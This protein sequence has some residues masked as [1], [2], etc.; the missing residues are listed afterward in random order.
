MTATAAATL[1]ALALL[2]S[3]LTSAR[4]AGIFTLAGAADRFS[5]CPGFDASG[6]PFR[7]GVPAT[8]ITH[9]CAGP[10]LVSLPS[11]DP[12][13][14]ARGKL[15]RLDGRGIIHHL[16]GGPTTGDL[17]DGGP[18]TAAGLQLYSD[19]GLAVDATGGVLV[20]DSSNGDRVRRIAPDG[21]IAT[22]AG[23]SPSSFGLDTEVPDGA[24]AV[25][26]PLP[27]GPLAAVSGGGFA[28]VTRDR[29]RI[30]AVRPD[31]TV[32]TLAGGLGQPP[33]PDFITALAAMPG[34]KL[35]FAADG[36]V[37]SLE[38]GGVARVLPGLPPGVH[39]LAAA[40]GGSLLAAT[41][42]Q[43]WLVEASG[44]ARLVAGRS[45]GRALDLVGRGDGRS[46][47]R[48]KIS[49][50]PGN[51]LT[52][53]TDGSFAILDQ[54]EGERA[55]RVRI[56]T[57][58]PSARLAAEILPGTLASRG[59]VKLSYVVT[60][61]ADVQV[62]IRHEGREIRRAR[63]TAVPGTNVL[64]LRRRLPDGQNVITLTATAGSGVATDRMAMLPNGFL[65]RRAAIAVI[66]AG[67]DSSTEP[68]G[69]PVGNAARAP[70]AADTYEIVH[71]VGCRRF[72]R[73]RVDC[74][75][76]ATDT[77]SGPSTWTGFTV[78]LGH[79][80]RIYVRTYSNAGKSD[81]HPRFHRH[82]RWRRR[83]LATAPILIL[84]GRSSR[85]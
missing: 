58:I 54:P 7:P 69:T 34:G 31:G 85:R 73:A 70:R 68:Y 75:R 10:G 12:V 29:E 60:A 38:P 71:I 67:E 27:A 80:G 74:V 19:G 32:A 20:S 26:G 52:A 43:A 55:E 63:D 28:L 2:A 53:L 84:G 64:T 37:Y 14:G 72:G 39:A 41:P 35:A 65:P 46:P 62:S 77:A 18:A 30:R 42:S 22:V 6:S 3:P 51:S 25:S 21:T 48:A 81:R 17:G 79:D 45:E 40:P 11:G 4:A 78:R 76:H 47:R 23:N 24:P 61:A 16:A 56:V 1:L 15:V 57:A 13:L 9:L 5:E 44:A 33:L 50:P 8:T 36:K 49:I 83:V 82:P 59:K 66:P